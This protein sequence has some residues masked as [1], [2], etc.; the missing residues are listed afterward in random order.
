MLLA[1]HQFFEN[2]KH[3]FTVRVNTFEVISKS[4]LESRRL[5]PL[6]DNRLGNI[7][8]TTQRVHRVTPEEK[9]VKH[10]RFA[11]GGQRIEVVSYLQVLHSNSPKEQYKHGASGEQVGKNPV[12]PESP[13]VHL[14]ETEADRRV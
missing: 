2:S 12:C 5:H 1:V 3:L 6:F 13:S 9:P 8:V 11:L 4:R 10:G 14:R 7:N